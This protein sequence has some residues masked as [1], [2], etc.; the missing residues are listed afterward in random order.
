[1]R[2]IPAHEGQ[3]ADMLPRSKGTTAMGWWDGKQKIREYLEK[4]NQEEKVS[5]LS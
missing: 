4:V 1:M 5:F 3:I 2:S